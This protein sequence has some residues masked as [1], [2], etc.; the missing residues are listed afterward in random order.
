LGEYKIALF[1]LDPYGNAGNTEVS[2]QVERAKFRIYPPHSLKADP[3]KVID[4]A[5]FV[6]YPNGT[7]LTDQFGGQV[8]VLTNSTTGESGQY[9]MFFNAT[10][11]RWHLYYTAPGLDMHFGTVVTFSFHATDEYENSGAAENAYQITV[12]A[13]TATLVLAVIV[14]A[15]VPV[16]LLAWAILTVTKRRRQYK[17]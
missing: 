12:G 2:T 14:A 3:G 15:V 6:T 7:L 5:F 9:T 17:P 13:D 10:D 11:R 16:I 4:I 8:T 1:A